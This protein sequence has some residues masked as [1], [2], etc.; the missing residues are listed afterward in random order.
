MPLYEF[1]CGRCN[2]DVELLVRSAAE[3]TEC[4]NCGS[5]K[6]ERLLSVAAAPAIQGKSLPVS[7][8]ATACGRSECASGRCMFGD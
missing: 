7:Q 5:P 6:L 3:K 1:H 4:P 8:A 2:A